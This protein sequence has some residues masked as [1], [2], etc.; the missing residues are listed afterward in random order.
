[1]DGGVDGWVDGCGWVDVDVDRWVAGWI[2]AV[3]LTG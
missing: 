2:D 1:M 3:I